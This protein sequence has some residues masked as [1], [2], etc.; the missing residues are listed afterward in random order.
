[1]SRSGEKGKKNPTKKQQ[2]LTAANSEGE[3]KKSL[4]CAREISEKEM[5][6]TCHEGISVSKFAG[7]DSISH[8]FKEYH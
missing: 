8:Q 6:Q 2:K 1:M 3:K 4:P 5:Q 7:K